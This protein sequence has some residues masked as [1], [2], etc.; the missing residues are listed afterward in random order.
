[1]WQ[2]N[3]LTICIDGFVN[4]FSEIKAKPTARQYHIGNLENWLKT[5]PYA[6]LT[7]E[8]HFK[9]PKTGH[10]L[11][12]D[13][14]PIVSKDR[15]PLRLVVDRWRWLRFQFRLGQRN[16]RIESDHIAYTS[17][18]GLDCFTNM[19][20]LVLGLAL[21]FGLIWWLNFVADD[22]HRLAIITG[23]ITAFTCVVWAAV[24]QRPLEILAATA[25]YAAV[26]MVF[27]QNDNGGSGGVTAT[28]H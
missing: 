12:G 15:S 9:D 14:F 20:I 11:E 16:D 28:N 1:M 25:A 19:L 23:F 3:V 6:V 7:S 17:E 4:S 5:H 13:L 10:L 27:L 26:L 2:R 8:Q 21:L 24:G 18:K 22:V